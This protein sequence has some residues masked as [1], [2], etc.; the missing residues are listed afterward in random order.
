MIFSCFS[1]PLYDAFEFAVGLRRN[2]NYLH[3]LVYYVF[4]VGLIEEALKVVPLLL[5][6]RLTDFID[7]PKDYL[8]YGSMSALGF[9]F[10]E[11]LLPGSE[12]K[13]DIISTR[14]LVAVVGHIT[15]TS[16]IMYGFFYTRYRIQKNPLPYFLLAFGAACALHGIS[17]FSAARGWGVLGFLIMIYLIRQYG[18]FIHDALNQSERNPD[19]PKRQFEL[20]QYLCYSLAAIIMF[21]YVVSAANVGPSNANSAFLW[22]AFLS[23]FWLCVILLNL[24]SLDIRKRQWLPLLRRK[25]IA[26]V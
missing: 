24:G 26:E 11:N 14:A 8:I 16:L 9:A 20:T 23:F 10:M 2:G 1:V 13:P 21:Q 22:T 3:D 4:V 18:V 25:A 6:M 5:A 15:Y 19:Q 17:D 7:K 12:W